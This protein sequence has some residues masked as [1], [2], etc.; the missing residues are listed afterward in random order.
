MSQQLGSL[1]DTGLVVDRREEL[2]V[3]YTF[4]MEA[5]E[6]LLNDAKRVASAVS[7]IDGV[8]LEF[9]PLPEANLKTAVVQHVSRPSCQPR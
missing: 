4:A 9:R 5:I 8:E 1:R 3:Y 6:T 2:N 7:G